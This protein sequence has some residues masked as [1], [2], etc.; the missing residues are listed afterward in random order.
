MT[1][2]RPVK[3]CTW[4]GVAG[5]R[6]PK[7]AGARYQPVRVRVFTAAGLLQLS[8]LPSGAEMWKGRKQPALLGTSGVN[9]HLRGYAGTGCQPTSAT[10]TRSAQP[11]SAD[12]P[13]RRA[14][15]VVPAGDKREPGRTGRIC[16]IGVPQGD[17]Q[18]SLTPTQASWQLRRVA[19]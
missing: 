9:R 1:P 11:I 18:P 16:V 19:A 5:A 3:A 13:S 17:V 10:G 4:R 15:P 12:A 8:T 7:M 2:G 14:D 6:A